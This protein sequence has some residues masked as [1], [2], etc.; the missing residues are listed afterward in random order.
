MDFVT[1][2]WEFDVQ[3]LARVAIDNEIRS[4]KWYSVKQKPPNPE[5]PRSQ[6]L[7]EVQKERMEKPPMRILAWDIE[8]AKQPLKFPD[9]NND[10]DE[11]MMISLMTN[12]NKGHLIVN[13]TIVSEDLADTEYIP[14]KEYAGYFA[15]HNV[16]DEKALLKK[17]FE[18]IRKIDPHVQVTFNGDNF[19]I[20][21][22]EKRCERYDINM[23]REIGLRK[24]SDD[25]Y[26][27]KWQLHLDCLYWV[28]R[29][30]Y[31]PCGARG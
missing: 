20:P 2:L 29:D 14:K 30:S 24:D 27:G 10:G 12:N 23:Y 11:I 7:L 22:V 4:G 31:L 25:C 26:I 9:A 13:R 17:F 6:V 18:L 8:T 19:D 28:I 1:K 16:P 15:T 5:N 3:Y 21:Y